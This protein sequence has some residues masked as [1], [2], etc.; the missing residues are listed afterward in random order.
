MDLSVAGTACVLH[1]REATV[2]FT[3]AP[4]STVIVQAGKDNDK[5]LQEF[6]QW[7]QNSDASL[8]SLQTLLPPSRFPPL[9]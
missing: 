1:R 2:K 6:Q 5:I 3:V 4:A 7:R 9:H 8:E